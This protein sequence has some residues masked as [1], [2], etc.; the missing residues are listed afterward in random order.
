M[1]ELGFTS[2]YWR[3]LIVDWELEAARHVAMHRP[4]MTE[5]LDDPVRTAT[6]RS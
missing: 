6:A 2:P 5:H 3:T 1:L 4:A